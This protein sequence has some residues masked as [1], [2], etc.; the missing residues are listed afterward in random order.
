M[1]RRRSRRRRRHTSRPRRRSAT[2]TTAGKW[3]RRGSAITITAAHTGRQCIPRRTVFP[4]QQAR[5]G[6]VA[7]RIDETP[8]AFVVVVVV[9]VAAFADARRRTRHRDS[10]MMA[11]RR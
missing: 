5:N 1:W 7:S 11:A 4:F 10:W 8:G 9:V 3:S 2:T 6:F